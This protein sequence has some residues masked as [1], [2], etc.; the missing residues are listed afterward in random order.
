M[1]NF[2]QVRG[3]HAHFVVAAVGE[4]LPREAGAAHAFGKSDVQMAARRFGG[5]RRTREIEMPEHAAEYGAEIV[6]GIARELAE[7][8]QA[9]GAQELRVLPEPVAGR[10]HPAPRHRA[11]APPCPYSAPRLRAGGAAVSMRVMALPSA[12]KKR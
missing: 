10:S 2:V 7:R 1:R 12:L 5:R 9:L 8:L 4:Q 6:R 3:L 11:A